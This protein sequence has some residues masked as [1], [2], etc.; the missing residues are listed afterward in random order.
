MFYTR[1]MTSLVLIQLIKVMLAYSARTERDAS[2]SSS[3][4]VDVTERSTLI[5][6]FQR[7]WFLS[8]TIRLI[9]GV[10]IK[11]AGQCLAQFMFFSE[12]VFQKKKNMFRFKR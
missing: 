3:L 5:G 9:V 8:G 7:R 12:A 6:H 11:V 4:S 10:P 1:P 2:I